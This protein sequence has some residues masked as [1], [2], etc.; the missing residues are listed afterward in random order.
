VVLKQEFHEP[1]VSGDFKAEFTQCDACGET[2]LSFE[3]AETFSRSYAAAV[4]RARGA[5]TPERILEAR[6]KL[7]WPHPRMEEAFGVGPKTWGR[8]ERGTVSPSGPAT[9]LLWLLENDKEAFL[10]LVEA[11]DPKKL[12]HVKIVGSIMQQAP[13]EEA[14]GFTHAKTLRR[15]RSVTVGNGEAGS[16]GGGPV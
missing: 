16:P 12:K 6:L 15:S 14:V 13:G 5:I 8:W 10:R 7:G 1:D 9:K 11:H 4:A 3:Q 2:L